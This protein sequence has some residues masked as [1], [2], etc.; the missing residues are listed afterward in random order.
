[1]TE[2]SE[3]L[4]KSVDLLECWSTSLDNNCS[5]CKMREVSRQLSLTWV[6]EVGV[7]VRE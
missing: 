2:E 6:H 4:G 1:M 5:S 3:K 7:G